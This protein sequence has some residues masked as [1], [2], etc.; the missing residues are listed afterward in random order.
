MNNLDLSKLDL[1]TYGVDAVQLPENHEE[2]IQKV[3][4]S[5]DFVNKNREELYCNKECQ[6]NRKE[7]ELYQQYM[8]RKTQLLN[9]PALLKESERK[10]ITFKEGS[11][12]YENMREKQLI[13]EINNISNELKN[14]YNSNYKSLELTLENYNDLGKYNTH[15]NELINMYNEKIKKNEQNINSTNNQNNI[16]DR[17][18]YYDMKKIA[19]WKRINQTIKYIIWFLVLVYLIILV[20]YKKYKERFF[21][22]GLIIGLVI[23]ILPFH[24]IIKYFYN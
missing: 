15:L 18:T 7:R 14:A 23:T 5:L 10:Y 21:I 22:V 12:E 11:T 8:K 1:N 24:T 2:M 4:D 13:N 16:A 3:S 17:N 6:Q 20:R 19:S 9:A